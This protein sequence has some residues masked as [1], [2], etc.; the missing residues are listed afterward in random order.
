MMKVM[1]E[2]NVGF[3]CAS[4]REIQLA[5][6]VGAKVEDIIYANPCK[7]KYD[8]VNAYKN[9]I[10]LTTFDSV[11]ELKKLLSLGNDF[12]CVLR[13]KI[14]N[15]SARIN[16]S[17]KYGATY[18]EYKDLINEAKKLNLDICGVSFHVGSA[19]S[20]PKIF[21]YAITLAKEVMDYAASV[22]YKDC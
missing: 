1:V 12:K 17:L 20:D 16:L 18:E 19:S 9:N 6:E 8:L 15:P 21:N 10:K 11:S 14:D 22:G 5:F 3:D 7:M 2:N 4:Y 13:I